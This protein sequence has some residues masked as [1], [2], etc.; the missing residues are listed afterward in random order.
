VTLTVS[1][2]T[3]GNY[4]NTLA[5]NALT[6]AQNA[7]NTVASSASLTV[8]APSGGGALNW[9]DLMLLTG[10]IVWRL[11]EYLPHRRCRRPHHV[12]AG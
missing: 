1:S 3:A 12:G 7:G 6:T 10:V 9:L 2:G 11:Y 5:A 4:T 8:T